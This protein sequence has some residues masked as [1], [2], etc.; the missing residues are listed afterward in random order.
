MINGTSSVLP[1]RAAKT[2]VG[3][4]IQISSIDSSSKRAWSGPDKE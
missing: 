3:E 2:L 1:F 4:L